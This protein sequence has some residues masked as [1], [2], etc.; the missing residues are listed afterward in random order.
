MGQ[1]ISYPVMGRYR[2]GYATTYLTG[3]EDLEVCVVHMRGH[4]DWSAP[5]APAYG[6][7]EPTSKLPRSAP[8][9]G[10]SERVTGCHD[11]GGNRPEKRG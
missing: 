5:R 7:D 8:V 4:D 2:G 10:G 6:Y 11:S 3:V 1:S 9:F